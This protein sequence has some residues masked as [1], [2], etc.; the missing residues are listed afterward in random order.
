MK[1][2][3]VLLGLLVLGLFVLTSCYQPE[4]PEGP[5]TM[6]DIP[7][8]KPPIV[9]PEPPTPPVDDNGVDDI[10]GDDNTVVPPPI[11]Q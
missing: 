11:P 2:A 8:E 1:I 7:P 6:P 4:I 3:R 9:P 10:F 5:G